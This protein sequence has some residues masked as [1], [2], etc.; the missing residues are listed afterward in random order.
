MA[1]KFKMPSIKDVEQEENKD[2][3][4]KEKFKVGA[5]LLSDISKGAVVMDV[6]NIPRDQI[7]KN[8]NNHYSISGIESLA[9]SIK[10]YGLL[11]PVHVM[12]TETG[13]RL[14]GGERR[15][16]AIDKLIADAGVPDWT[17]D[18]LIPCVIKGAEDVKL[19]LSPEN[20]ERYAIIT[21]NREQRAYTDGDR[22]MEIQEWKKIIEELRSKGIEYINGVDNEGNE[23]QVGIKGEKTR[24]ILAQTTGM[25]RGQINNYE[26]VHNSGSEKLK[27]ALLQGKISVSAA[28]KAAKELSDKEQDSIAEAAEQGEKVT[29]ADISTQANKEFILTQSEFKKDIKNILSAIKEKEITL[30]GQDQEKYHFH[31]RQLEKLIGGQK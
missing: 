15:L 18:T 30:D 9:E 23:K 8:P 12:E 6:V 13:Y 14:L 26:A 20:K 24:D 27:D 22:Y 31:I 5:G 25:S 2:V 21:S 4:V 11:Q 3:V 16:T 10:Q 29:P 28:A 19:D 17:E 7:Q 1:G